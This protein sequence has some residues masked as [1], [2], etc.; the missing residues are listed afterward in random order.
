MFQYWQ[1]KHQQ[2]QFLQVKAQ[3]NMIKHKKLVAN[4]WRT[5]TGCQLNSSLAKASGIVECKIFG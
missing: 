4:D 2:F 5:W 3:P 1:K